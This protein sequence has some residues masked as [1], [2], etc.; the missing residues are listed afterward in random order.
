MT[1]AW[2]LALLLL[3]LPYLIWRLKPTDSNESAIRVPFFNEILSATST[4]K[5]GSLKNA[6]LIPLIVLALAWLFFVIALTRPQTFGD[7][8]QSPNT[9]RDLM[10]AVDLSGSMSERDLKL[11]NAPVT[12]LNVVKVLGAEFLNQRQGDRVGLVVFGSKAYL[13]SP[14]S[15]DLDAIKTML[16]EAQIGLP[17]RRQT[18]IGDAIGLAV[19]KL[20]EQD[21]EE[22][23][24]IL[25]TDGANTSGEIS[26]L[27]AAELARKSEVKIY[28]IG[29]GADSITK[30]GFFGPE[31]TNP[32]ADL[33]ENTL[34][35]IAET[36]D[37]QYFRAKTTDDL[38]GIYSII[39]DLEPVEKDDENLR[40]AF[41]WY[42]YPLA[43]SFSLLVLFLYRFKELS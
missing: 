8:I 18:T 9:G 21:I 23:V 12:R 2:P 28:T 27:Q 32:S 43:I 15:R 1:F 10:M 14:I 40:Q 29:I 13:Y 42:H 5:N 17:G 37:G 38:R 3:P 4:G 33:D 6:F 35:K 36:T 11:N 20:N 25:L 26:P 24:L 16:L 31:T 39:D 30:Q 19:K 7:S 22:K 34:I 41:E